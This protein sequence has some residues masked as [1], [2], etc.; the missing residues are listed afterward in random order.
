MFCKTYWN[1]KREWWATHDGVV[2]KLNLISPLSQILIG[3]FI[4]EI[5]FSIDLDFWG[6]Y[7]QPIAQ[8][9]RAK[10]YS[11]QLGQWNLPIDKISHFFLTYVTNV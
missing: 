10:I 4:Q 9:G 1:W 6:E 8:V 2:N 11:P 7:R 5:T 3:Q